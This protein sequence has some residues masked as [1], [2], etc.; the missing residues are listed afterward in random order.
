MMKQ[1]AGRLRVRLSGRADKALSRLSAKHARQIAGRI[2]ALA[3]DPE[4]L[5]SAELRGMPPWRRL[6]SGKYRI[7]YRVDGNQLLV[8]LISE[9]N[10]DRVYR[11]IKRI[12]R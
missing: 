9:R 2:D 1:P 12:E 3:D 4:P 8:A 7:I 10:D 5:L 11:I 6:R